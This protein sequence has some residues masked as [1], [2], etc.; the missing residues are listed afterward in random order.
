MLLCLLIRCQ[1]IA[2]QLQ[3]HHRS[4]VRLTYRVVNFESDSLAFLVDRILHEPFRGTDLLM[5]C[6]PAR[7]PKMRQQGSRYAN[8][9]IVE[10]IG[11]QSPIS[12]I[13][14][15]IQSEA[16]QGNEYADGEGAAN[17]PSWFLVWGHGTKNLSSGLLR[18]RVDDSAKRLNSKL[19]S[20]RNSV[21]PAV[22]RDP[23]EERPQAT[24][25]SL[26]KAFPLW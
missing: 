21:K 12:A 17:P 7:N 11:R 6:V 24:G 16:G 15:N 26:L 8:R 23:R 22:L 5:L 18:G 9:Q 13:E 10:G 20:A 2:R 25:A 14:E 19:A 3:V 4:G 1:G